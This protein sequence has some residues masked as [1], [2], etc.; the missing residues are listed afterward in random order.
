MFK[1]PKGFSLVCVVTVLILS[2]ITPVAFALNPQPEPPAP[3]TVMIDQTLLQTDVSPII[4]NGR[5]LVPLRA[6]FEALGAEVIW[7]P[8]DRSIEA[9]KGSLSIQLQIGNVSALK[10]GVPVTIDVPPS[11]VD[12]RTLVPVRFVSEALGSEVGWDETKRQVS[13][14]TSGGTQSPNPSVL[15]PSVST[16]P[17]VT[18]PS[19]NRLRILETPNFDPKKPSLLLSNNKTVPLMPIGPEIIKAPVSFKPN[20]PTP[21]AVAERLKIV[22]PKATVDWRQHQTSIKDQDG[23]NTCVTYAVLAAMEAYYKRLDPVKYQNIDLSEQYGHYLQKLVFLQD[24]PRDSSFKYENA[25]GRWGYS[26]TLYAMTLFSRLY[27]VPEEKL[28]PYIG[29]GS[30]EATWEKDDDPY[31]DPADVWLSQYK[32]GNTNFQESDFPQSALN[33]A[34]YGITSFAFIP[35]ENRKNLDY[36]RSVLAA[37]FE[38]AFSAAIMTPDPSP[39]DAIWHPGT[40]EVGGHAMLMVGYD[41]DRECF[42]VKNSW[43][44]D[45]PLE[46]GYTL[47]SYDWVTSGYVFEAGYITGV[48][49]NPTQY[50]RPEQRFLGRWNLDYDG[51]KGILDIYHI[52][53]FFQNDWPRDSA[54]GSSDQRIGTFYDQEFKSYRVNGSIKGNRIEFYIDFDKP[55]LKYHELSGKPFYGY[56]F[57]WEPTLMAGSM[58]S[59]GQ[60]YGFYATKK[61]W[62]NGTGAAESGIKPTDYSGTWQMNHDGWKGTLTIYSVDSTTNKIKASYKTSNGKVLPVNGY[63][64]EGR[65]LMMDIAFDENKP[66]NF[67]G[68]I[69]S[70][71]KGLM[72][73]STPQGGS[74][75]GWLAVRTGPPPVMKITKPEDLPVLDPPSL[76]ELTPQLPV[77]PIIKLPQTIVR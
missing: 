23:R 46:N 27:G 9:K 10:N 72:A 3:I 21:A 39:D 43:G 77:T 28:L 30:Y 31:L 13:I 61:D 48:I 75:Y 11:I 55:N 12:N 74:T 70:W 18:T 14:R 29:G 35:W 49:Q 15:V 4:E 2:F 58:A 62:L 52:P 7:N 6:I 24:A 53:G 36:Y 57:G 32:V 66:Q 8:D 42:I 47:F 64:T 69:F 45:N 22:P 59:D 5:T 16:L 44:N 54:F 26:G 71:E 19:V 50:T 73:G 37:G 56:L 33:G 63:V 1:K 76:K 67:S 20:Y 38:I 41:D 40:K 65:R 25:V 68:L 17:T 34:T 60:P 51:W